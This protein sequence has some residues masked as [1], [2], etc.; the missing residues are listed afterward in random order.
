MQLLQNK[1]R[2]EFLERLGRDALCNFHYAAFSKGCISMEDL[3]YE[4]SSLNAFR[5]VKLWGNRCYIRG[6]R[7]QT[8]KVYDR[9]KIK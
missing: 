1:Y 7:S 2:N 8:G 5:K 9:G 6:F 4:K 3:C